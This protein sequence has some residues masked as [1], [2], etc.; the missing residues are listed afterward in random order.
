MKYPIDPLYAAIVAVFPQVRSLGKHNRRKIGSSSTWSD[1]SW[2]AA[3]DIRPPADDLY[4]VVSGSKWAPITKNTLDAVYAQLL[5]W[6]NQGR[7][8]GPKGERIGLILWRVADH[9][10][11]IHVEFIPKFSERYGTPPSY[12]DFDEWVSEVYLGGAA[13]MSAMQVIDIQRAC[14]QAGLTDMNGEPLK[15]D[16]Q[17]GAK[18]EYALVT[19]LS[20]GEHADRKSRRRI[21]RITK[22]LENAK[23]DI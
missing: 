23:V 11:H 12:A 20:G 8:F 7:T 13:D 3:W 22:R 15:E 6:R 18:T 14:N 4:Q 2:A 10:N 17:Y 9:Y 1:H 16:D 19:G 21:R 5:A